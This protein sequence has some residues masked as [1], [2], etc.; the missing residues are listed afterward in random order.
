MTIAEARAL[1]VGSE[2]MVTG[3]VTVE[4]GRLLGERTMAIQD[5]SAGVFVRLPEGY[6]VSEMPRGRIVQVHGELSAPFG[7]LEMRPLESADVV[8]I[9]SGG[10]PTPVPVTSLGIDESSEGLLAKGG[11]TVISVERRTGGAFSVTLR[12]DEGTAQVYV[13]AEL[14]LD[15]ASVQRGQRLT[16]TGIVGQRASGAGAADGYR[17]RHLSTTRGDAA[18]RSRPPRQPA[19]PRATSAG[20]HPGRRPRRQPD[21]RRHGD[22]GLGPHR[23]RGT[24]SHRRGR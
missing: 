8:A 1:P 11:G 23:L 5:G 22:L 12:D 2:P 20:P 4:P 9:G 10:L 16:V 24:T 18:S 17:G 7:N 14:G 3:V 19:A 13:H 6:P 15:A 21:H